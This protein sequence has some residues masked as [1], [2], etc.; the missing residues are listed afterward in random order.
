MS[1]KILVVDDEW[2]FAEFLSFNLTA[3]GFKVVAASNGLDAL[4]K[5]RRFL[6]E[7]VVLDLMMEGMDGYSVCE[8]LRRHPSTTTSAII[9]ITAAGGQMAR[10]NALAAGADDFLAKPFS[11][12]ELVRRTKQV[13]ENRE[14]K[15]SREI[16]IQH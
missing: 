14:R 11:A 15:R 6:P 3:H 16:P 10:M 7:L 12:H 5:A 9:I 2:D 4:A 8:V 13:L 1:A